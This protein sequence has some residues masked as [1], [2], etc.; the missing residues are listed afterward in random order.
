M[1]N[2]AATPKER[3]ASYKQACE[4]PSNLEFAP[5][6]PNLRGFLYYPMALLYRQLNNTHTA[7]SLLQ[8]TA[9]ES[10]DKPSL[11][12]YYQALALR[13]L[14]RTEEADRILEVLR[15]EGR[16]LIEGTAVGYE[17]RSGEYRKALGYYYLAIA[18]SAFRLVEETREALKNAIELRPL[19]E[20]EALIYAQIAYA[21]ANQ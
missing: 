2:K 8:I 1:A 6:E 9:Q 19:I 3:L 11:V 7:D 4:Y 16:Q 12:T 20:R 15:N 17:R 18:Q 13:E 10:T 14:G 5:R 21:G